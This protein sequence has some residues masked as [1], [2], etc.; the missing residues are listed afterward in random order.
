MATQR[1]A[2][3]LIYRRE[4]SA[5]PGSPVQLASILRRWDL[6]LMRK[7]REQIAAGSG[8]PQHRQ[9][10]GGSGDKDA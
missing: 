2:P 5:S 4:R 6:M 3:E 8:D 9:T 10:D 1:R 7:A